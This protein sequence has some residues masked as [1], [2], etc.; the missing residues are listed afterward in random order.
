LDFG[1]ARDETYELDFKIQA[2]KA[3]IQNPKSKI[4]NGLW[5]LFRRNLR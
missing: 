1:L 4:Q 3:L 5:Q 2:D